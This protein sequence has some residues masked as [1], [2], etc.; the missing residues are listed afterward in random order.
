MTFDNRGGEKRS[1]LSSRAMVARLL[2]GLAVAG[3]AYLAFVALTNGQVA[4]CGAGGGCDSVL[5]SRW[6]Y[7]LNLPVSVPAFFVYVGL[8]VCALLVGRKSNA[9]SERGAWAA[10]VVLSS[11]AIGGALWFIGI[12]LLVIKAICPVCMGVHL[13]AALAS[14]ILLLNIPL[15]KDPT[16]PMWS[17]APEKQGVPGHAILSLVLLG[18]IGVGVLAVVQIAAPSERNLVKVIPPSRGEPSTNANQPQAPVIS[19]SPASPNLQR[20]SPEWLSLYGG[21]FTIMLNEVP[22]MGSPASS[23]IIVYLFDYTCTHCRDLHHILAAARQQ[24]SNTLAVVTL[25]MPMSSNCNHLIP[26]EFTSSADACEYANL[27]LALW[28]TSP[29]NY[30]GYDEWFFSQ[31]P[32]PPV[33]AARAK[34]VE[35]AGRTNLEAALADPWVAQQIDFSTR[36][37]FAN[38]QAS[39]RPAMPQIVMGTAI[40]VGPLISVRHL[41]ALLNRYLGIEPPPRIRPQSAAPPTR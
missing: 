41:Y 10:I 36:L 5:Q 2:L 24:L 33:E 30:N 29:T 34:A 17:S 23:N 22:M 16:T 9:D 37:H 18:I 38:W 31:E 1:A 39:G 27:G 35:L 12:Q 21:R 19:P 26:A 13:S 25:P 4:G 32:L 20:I 40:S 7:W 6:A 14:T 15:A 3:A 8:L 28:R 11:V